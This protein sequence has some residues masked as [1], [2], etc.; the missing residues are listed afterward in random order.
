MFSFYAQ[1]SPYMNTEIP[2]FIFM[3]MPHSAAVIQV[4]HIR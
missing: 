2:V 4:H 1:G 3:N